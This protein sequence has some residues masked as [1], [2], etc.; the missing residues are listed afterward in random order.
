MA[1]KAEAGFN[2]GY[3]GKIEAEYRTNYVDPGF[4]GFLVVNAG[5]RMEFDYLKPNKTWYISVVVLLDAEKVHIIANKALLPALRMILGFTKKG[6][7]EFTKV[8]KGKEW[9]V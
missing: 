1:K 9:R 2:F 6:K 4:E 8:A 3:S 7:F 5:T